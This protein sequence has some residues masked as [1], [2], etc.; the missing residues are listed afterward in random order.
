[1]LGG[2]F[3]VG[4]SVTIAQVVATNPFHSTGLPSYLQPPSASPNIYVR[5]ANHLLICH[6]FS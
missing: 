2:E 6:Y 5:F 1:M 3:N 4:P